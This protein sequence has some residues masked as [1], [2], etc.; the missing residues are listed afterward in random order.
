MYL[1]A[2]PGSARLPFLLLAPAC[3]LPGIVIALQH[4]TVPPG[5]ILLVLLAGVAAHAAV[6][7]LNEY[8]DFSSGLDYATRPTPFSGG[9]GTLPAHPEAAGSVKRAAFFCMGLTVLIGL[10]FVY[11][12][13]PLLLLP[14]ITGLLLIISYTRWINRLPLLCLISPGI[15]FGPLMLAGS[16]LA[17]SGQNSTAGL[18]ASLMV[19]CLVNNLLLLNQYPDMEADS[20]FGRR[21]FVLHFGI[22]AANRVY[23]LFLLIAAT[24][25]S[26]AVTLGIFPPQ[27]EWTL[28]GLLPA[29]FSAIGAFRLRENI[30]Q[31]P[32]YLACNVATALITPLILA[33]SLSQ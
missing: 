5:H 18:A 24:T 25:V 4:G 21:H 29:L 8:Q 20:H 26:M 30:G 33:I 15:A 28:L 3:I 2:L 31:Q 14:G 9:S 17:L 7:L 19:F 22:A 6:N 10:Y 12:Q 27:A 32:F 1:K 23:L 13:G 16:E 11:L